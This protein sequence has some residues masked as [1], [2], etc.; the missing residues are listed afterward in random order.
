MVGGRGAWRS[1][2]AAAERPAARE[3]CEAARVRRA[4]PSLL[5]WICAPIPP[6]RIGALRRWLGLLHAGR[7]FRRIPRHGPPHL[8][9][10]RDFGRVH[11]SLP[12][13]RGRRA[14]RLLDSAH[15]SER[16]D[17]LRAQC[18]RGRRADGSRREE[19]PLTRA[20]SRTCDE[21]GGSPRSPRPAS[22]CARS[23]H[24]RTILFV[25]PI[26]HLFRPLRRARTSLGRPVFFWVGLLF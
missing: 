2:G 22:R 19:L 4:A 8:R 9:S 13:D 11:R 6:L 1:R 10:Q 3:V 14:T 18:S 17:A 16:G 25:T 21:G 12:G 23:N 5:A 24:V 26:R 7:A 20:S 15:G